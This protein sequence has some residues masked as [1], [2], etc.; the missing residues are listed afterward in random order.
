MMKLKNEGYARKGI[1]QLMLRQYVRAVDSLETALALFLQTFVS[2][3]LG[4][5]AGE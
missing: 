4:A 3:A 1:A 2:S 5:A